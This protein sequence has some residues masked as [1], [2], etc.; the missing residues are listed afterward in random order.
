[1]KPLEFIGFLIVFSSVLFLAYIATR[2][3]S[4]KANKAMKGK[5]IS[6]VE[7]VSL[8]L[9]KQVHMLKVGEQFILIASSGK[10]IEFLTAVKLDNY[11]EQAHTDIG[12]GFDFKSTFDKCINA[13]KDKKSTRGESVNLDDFEQRIQENVFKSNLEKLR[14]MASGSDKEEIRDGVE[15]TNDV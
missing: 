9:D 2:F 5:H 3:V 6:I 10:N 14:A 15:S 1:M 13:I 12:F 7:T 8:G 11:E 4:G